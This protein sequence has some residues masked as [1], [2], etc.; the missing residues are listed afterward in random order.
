MSF[1]EMWAFFKV[2]WYRIIGAY[3]LLLTPIFAT[4]YISP[5]GGLYLIWDNGPRIT[6]TCPR[7]QQQK[8]DPL[9]IHFNS[10]PVDKTPRKPR[11]KP[12]DLMIIHQV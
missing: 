9:P 7:W 8:L 6:N 5:C 4:A 11:H 12:Q 10:V 1:S 3:T 2:N